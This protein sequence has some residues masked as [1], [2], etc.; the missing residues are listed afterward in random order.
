MPATSQFKVMLLAR[1][2]FH[3]GFD[4]QQQQHAFI[5]PRPAA[6]VLITSGM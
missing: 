2:Q 6:G 3:S 1:N 5:A 4:V